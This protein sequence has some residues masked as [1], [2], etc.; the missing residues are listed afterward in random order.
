ME[1]SISMKIL[2]LLISNGLLPKKDSS[3]IFLKESYNKIEFIKNCLIN[4]DFSY[5][6]IFK[7]FKEENRQI[8]FDR[9]S[10]L[11]L[12][13]NKEMVIDSL[14]KKSKSFITIQQSLENKYKEIKQY[15]DSLILYGDYLANFAYYQY[16][17]ELVEIINLIYF[18]ENSKINKISKEE[19]L[20]IQKYEMGKK[21]K[22][23]IN[24]QKV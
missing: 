1:D 14:Y 5:N 16:H 9:I 12:I 17:T 18:F 10:L 4:N 13:D 8:F 24:F 23:E 20:K 19:I 2:I 15:I 22:K 21:Q 7:F 11:Y 6:N 3:N